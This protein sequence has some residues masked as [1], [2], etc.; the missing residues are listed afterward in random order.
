[1]VRADCNGPT[2]ATPSRP[3]GAVQPQIEAARS[4]AMALMATGR[5][6]IRELGEN[7]PASDI[8]TPGGWLRASADGVDRFQRVEGVR[9]RAKVVAL[10]IDELPLSIAPNPDDGHVRKAASDV[11]RLT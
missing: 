6:G 11:I 10:L 3:S 8:R 4:N 1:M 2:L 7:S 5:S 9:D